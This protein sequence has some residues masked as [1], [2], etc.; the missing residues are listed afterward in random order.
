MKLIILLSII[1]NIYS[2]RRVCTWWNENGGGNII[3][4]DRHNVYCNAGE[5]MTGFVIQA[6]VGPDNNGG[7][8]VCYECLAKLAVF[9]NEVIYAETV[10]V[11]AAESILEQDRSADSLKNIGVWCPADWGIRGWRLITSCNGSFFDSR[12]DMK[13]GY[14]CVALKVTGAVQTTTNMEDSNDGRNW[15]LW[16][17]QIWLGGL[18]VLSG[19]QLE[20]E[21]Y[22]RIFS[23]SGRRFRM[24]FNYL[25]LRD[26]EG[27]QERFESAVANGEYYAPF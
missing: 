7:L 19:F 22:S 24:R 16:H 4:L 13:F 10:W 21:Y 15:D 3:Y 2:N 18:N 20:V 14:H 5:V 23:F 1:V 6:P 12:C 26:V 27:E 9:D 11:K 17:T 25:V 8:N